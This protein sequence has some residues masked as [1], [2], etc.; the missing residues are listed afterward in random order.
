MG[1]RRNFRRGGGGANPKR[2]PPPHREKNRK[3]APILGE[4]RTEKGPHME[5]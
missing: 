4:E 2:L 5:K 1:A 3:M